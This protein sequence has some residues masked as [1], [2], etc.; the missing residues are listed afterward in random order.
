VKSNSKNLVWRRKFHQHLP[1]DRA[2]PVLPHKPI[3]MEGEDRGFVSQVP[4][5]VHSK[6]RRVRKRRQKALPVEN[7]V[8][9]TSEGPVGSKILVPCAQPCILRWSHQ[10]IR[11]EDLQKAVMLTIISDRVRVLVSELAK[12]LAPR[13]EIEEISMVL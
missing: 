10:M 9:A 2:A 12:L 6:R 1:E 4:N 3:P 7:P 8:P 13:L 11:A 5:G